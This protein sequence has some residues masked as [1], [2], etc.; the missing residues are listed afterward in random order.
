MGRSGGGRLFVA[1]A[2]L[3]GFDPELYLQEL[4]TVLP[5]YPMR[6]VLDLAPCN[7]VQTRQRLIEAGRLKY[8]DLAKI[9]G[10][11]LTFRPS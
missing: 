4:L 10:S 3:H 6:Q 7:R 5:L 2:E 1:S 11:R 9:T 8:I